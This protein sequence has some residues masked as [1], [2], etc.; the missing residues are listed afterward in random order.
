MQDTFNQL[1]VGMIFKQKIVSGFRPVGSEVEILEVKNSIVRIAHLPKNETAILGDDITY[2]G[3]Q[4]LLN[5]Y[6]LK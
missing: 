1:E 2:I 5:K 6:E 4:Q 3:K